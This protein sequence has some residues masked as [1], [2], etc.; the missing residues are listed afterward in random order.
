MNKLKPVTSKL[1][2]ALQDIGKFRF[3]NLQFATKLANERFWTSWKPVRNVLD[4]FIAYFRPTW[5]LFV[6]QL[7]SS[8]FLSNATCWGVIYGT[9]GDTCAT[10]QPSLVMQANHTEPLITTLPFKIVSIETLVKPL[11][12]QPNV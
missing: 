7:V 10:L 6:Y 2:I 4:G 8:H 9:L 1:Q 3:R 12:F 11:Y 5:T